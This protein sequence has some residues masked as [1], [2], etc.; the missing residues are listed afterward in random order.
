MWSYR[1]GPYPED[2]T[3]NSDPIR[4]REQ[5]SIARDLTVPLR[6]DEIAWL[7]ADIESATRSH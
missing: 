5:E 1:Y 7:D 4:L 2:V 3:T 6:E